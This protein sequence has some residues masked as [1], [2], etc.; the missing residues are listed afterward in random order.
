[1]KALLDVNVLIALLDLNHVHHAKA[2][3]WF[4]NNLNLGWATCPITENGCIRILSQPKYSN[5]LSI[6]DAV[7]R[8]RTLVAS[9]FYEF[10]PDGVS[11]HDSAAV[12][13]S[14]LSG[15]RQLTDV[16]LLALAVNHNMRLATFDGG[17]PLAPV[18]G[19]SQ[20]NLVVI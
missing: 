13:V 2:M 9:P 8:L 1:M 15:H 18:V 10:V 14:L 16:Y 19:A 11:L 7:Q 3:K 5:Q 6:S 20:S 12:N 17:I 4:Q